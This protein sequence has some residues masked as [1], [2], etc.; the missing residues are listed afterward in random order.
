MCRIEVFK[1]ACLWMPE[2][3]DRGIVAHRGLIRGGSRNA[4]GNHFNDDPLGP[5]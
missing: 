4:M 5:S 3:A 2:H 1:E